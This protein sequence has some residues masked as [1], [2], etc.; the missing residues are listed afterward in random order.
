MEDLNNTNT[1]EINQ[2]ANNFSQT[3]ILS[4]N[5]S[6]NTSKYS[7]HNKNNHIQKMK[8]NKEQEKDEEIKGEEETK[9]A[10]FFQE[11]YSREIELIS[12]LKNNFYKKF[13]EKNVFCDFREDE[14]K[15]WKIGFIK[16]FWRYILNH[17]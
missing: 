6:D 17:L 1:S 12:Y 10:I 14:K 9:K 5:S 15:P 8:A 2:S 4:T 7:H 13:Y 3:S 16:E 11:E